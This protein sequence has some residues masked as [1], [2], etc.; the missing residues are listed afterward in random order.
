M[1]RCCPWAHTDGDALAQ[2]AGFARFVS[3]NPNRRCGLSSRHRGDRIVPGAPGGASEHKP[4]FGPPAAIVLATPPGESASLHHDLAI[5]VLPRSC[6]R[7]LCPRRSGSASAL[8][9]GTRPRVLA[10]R[11]FA[12]IRD[13]SVR[14][15]ARELAMS[16]AAPCASGVSV[17]KRASI[18]RRLRTTPVAQAYNVGA[19]AFGNGRPLSRQ[20][21]R[22][23][24]H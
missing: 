17:Q 10:D 16:R 8:A 20:S 9:R 4:R 6:S 7:S 11:R 3:G 18:E 12:R 23:R 14:P 24:S 5:L 1:R 2:L 19:R 21:E 22:R 13:D 15:A